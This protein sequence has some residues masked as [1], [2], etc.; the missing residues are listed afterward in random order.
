MIREIL[1]QHLDDLIDLYERWLSVKEAEEQEDSLLVQRLNAHIDGW[2]LGGD[3]SAAILA[4]VDDQPGPGR[5]FARYVLELRGNEIEVEDI[6]EPDEQIKMH[7]SS[8]R[9]REI[10]L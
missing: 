3:E 5:T 1:E 2:A 10:L 4:D 6:P 9:N 8:L 7:Y